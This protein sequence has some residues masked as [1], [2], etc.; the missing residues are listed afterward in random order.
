[1]RNVTPPVSGWIGYP[2]GFLATV[3]V[4]IGA[5][6][7]QGTAHPDWVLGGLAV[8]VALVSAVTVL[9]AA[10]ATASVAWALQAG[11]VLGRHGE[12]V[13]TPRSLVAMVVLVSVAFGVYGV[14]LAVRLFRQARPARLE[15]GAFGVVGDQGDRLVVGGDGRRGAAEAGEQVRARGGQAV[16][17]R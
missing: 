1:M 8:T 11:F 4:T 9:R 10:L 15:E 7:V 2:L 5:V 16:V 13:F 14:S 6:A 17:A 3:V 12:L